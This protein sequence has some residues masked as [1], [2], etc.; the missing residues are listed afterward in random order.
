MTQARLITRAYKSDLVAWPEVA[1]PGT[2]SQASKHKQLF[3]P[4]VSQNFFRKPG[5]R[6]LETEDLSK[7]PHPP[8][9]HLNL[10]LSSFT[11]FSP[12]LLLPGTQFPKMCAF[13]PFSRGVLGL[14]VTPP[15]LKCL[16]HSVLL[17]LTWKLY[18]ITVFIISSVLGTNPRQAPHCLTYIHCPC[19]TFQIKHC[20]GCYYCC[21]G[22]L[23]I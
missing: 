8:C 7:E 3:S 13:G 19:G 20:C 14:S 11:C 17:Q 22:F 21:L 23:M 12:P 4:T 5:S 1:V 9:G 15:P 18:F 2:A 10:G 16:F 6:S